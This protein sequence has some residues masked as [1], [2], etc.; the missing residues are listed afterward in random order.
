MFVLRPLLLGWK[1]VII[2]TSSLAS[3]QFRYLTRWGFFNEREQP[4]IDL[5]F[6]GVRANDL[7]CGPFVGGIQHSAMMVCMSSID[8]LDLADVI[9]A[10]SAHVTQIDE[11][12]SPPSIVQ[13]DLQ[14]PTDGQG[15]TAILTELVRCHIAIPPILQRRRLWCRCHRRGSQPSERLPRTKKSCPYTRCWPPMCL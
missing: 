6:A 1:G 3:F 4:F 8:L 10:E 5:P 12:P 2:L 14:C 9:C 13:R 11:L 15:T 7:P